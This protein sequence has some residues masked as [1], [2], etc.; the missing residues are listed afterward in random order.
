VLSVVILPDVVSADRS[1]PTALAS[2]W[3]GRCYPVVSASY[4]GG[5]CDGNGPDWQYN[6]HVYCTASGGRFYYAWGPT[7]WAGDRRG[8]YASCDA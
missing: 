4:G 2:G 8:S 5:W 3:I 1:Q 7:R 6:G